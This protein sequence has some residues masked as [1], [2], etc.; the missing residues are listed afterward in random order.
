MLEYNPTKAL[1]HWGAT[2]LRVSMPHRE[3]LSEQPR[4]ERFNLPDV[5]DL[6]SYEKMGDQEVSRPTTQPE[7]SL[8]QPRLDAEDRAR[9]FAVYEQM[10]DGE[11]RQFLALRYGFDGETVHSC[12]ALAIH[13]GKDNRSWTTRRLTKIK[14]ERQIE[15]KLAKARFSPAELERAK[16]VYEQLKDGEDRQLL[17]MRYGLG[18]E[19]THSCRDLAALHSKSSTW[20]QNR[21]NETLGDP[22]VKYQQGAR[23]NPEEEQAARSVYEQLKDDED[24]QLLALRFGFDGQK[25]HTLQELC[26]FYDCSQTLIQANLDKII[27]N[28]EAGNIKAGEARFSE[29]E[30]LEARKTY[31]I[32]PDNEDRQRLAMRYG[33]GGKEHHTYKA[34]S[35]IYG[36]STAQLRRQITSIR[37]KGRS[38]RGTHGPRFNP[39]EVTA[40]QQIYEQ[41]ED[42]E[43]L[44][45][46]ALR[47][48]FDGEKRHTYKDL[49]QRVNKAKTSVR[50]NVCRLLECQDV[51]QTYGVLIDAEERQAAEVIYNQMP[52]GEERQIVALR[53]G[54]GGKRPHTYV[55]IGKLRNRSPMAVNNLV[56]HLLQSDKVSL[57]RIIQKA[58]ELLTAEKVYVLLKDEESRKLLA[59]RFAFGGKKRHT[60]EQI[61]QDYGRS[62]HWAKK[63]IDDLLAGKKSKTPSDPHFQLSKQRA[64]WLIYNSPAGQEN[65]LLAMRYGFDGQEEHT[66]EQIAHRKGKSRTTIVRNIKALFSEEILAQIPETYWTQDEHELVLGGMTAVSGERHALFKHLPLAWPKL[67]TNEKKIIILR[68]GLASQAVHSVEEINNLLFDGTSIWQQKIKN[69]LRTVE[70]EMWLGDRSRESHRVIPTQAT[71]GA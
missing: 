61:G 69:L 45:L 56:L 48:G 64:A 26:Q 40:A 3:I 1:G 67:D 53:F 58:E 52:A 12:Q 47:F 57:R 32:L 19:T 41:L 44:Q 30:L 6:S 37:R 43:D 29:Q 8:G 36:E 34:L 42:A 11:D 4:T 60:Y 68:H 2:F 31:D 27:G 17:A 59:L 28:T 16:M 39:E 35:R 14:R 55:E 23:I 65:E 10:E 38:F 13:Y 51:W 63:R 50:Y 49:A 21:L 20:L 24:L 46:L 70:R 7:E 71:K 25:R 9:V 15:S 22:M 5:S 62:R 33:L 66:Y 18:G 54:F